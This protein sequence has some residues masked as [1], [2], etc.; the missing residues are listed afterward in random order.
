MARLKTAL[1]LVAIATVAA[2]IT[3]ELMTGAALGY[4]LITAGALVFAISTKLKE[5]SSKTILVVILCVGLMLPGCAWLRETGIGLTEEDLL[6]AEAARVIAKNLLETWPI[7]SGFIRG[8]LGPRMKQLP[9]E[10]AEA[11]DELDKYAAQ[12]EW[13]DYELGYTLGCRVRMLSE[14]VMAA[15]KSFAPKVFAAMPKSL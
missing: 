1:Q 10:V 13:T 5:G 3:F 14:L 11:M 7:N 8:A 12:T 2:G 9:L 6:N 4:V 15:I